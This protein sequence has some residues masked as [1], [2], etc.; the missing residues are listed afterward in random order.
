MQDVELVHLTV[1][2]DSPQLEVHWELREQTDW[3]EL[4]LTVVSEE[5]A[6]SREISDILL[7]HPLN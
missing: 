5:R 3:T 4:H 7:Q 1:Q 2:A 6:C